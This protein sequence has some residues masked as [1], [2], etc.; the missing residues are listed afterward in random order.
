MNKVLDSPLTTRLLRTVGVEPVQYRLLL[1]LFSKLRDRQEFE[2]GAAHVSALK[3]VG[4]VAFFS[5]LV[6]FIVAFIVKAPLAVFAR[7]NY[8]LTAFLVL[9]ILLSEAINTFLNPVESAALAHQ[10]IREKSYFAA[11]LSYLLLITA[12]V[13]FP[14]NLVPSLLG[15]NLIGAR[16]F[17]PLL[18]LTSAY[19]LG[20]FIA[21]IGCGFLGILMR[22]IP[23][24]RVRSSVLWLQILFFGL[25]AVWPQLLQLLRPLRGPNSHLNPIYSSSIP[26]NWFVSLALL[27]SAETLDLHWLAIPSAFLCG[28]VV[29]FG[30]S[31]LTHGYLAQVHSLLRSGHGTQRRRSGW[32]GEAV[33]F[34]TGRQSGRAAFAFTYRMARTDWQFR[35]AVY[36][37]LIQLMIF[38][39]IAM[40]RAGIRISPFQPGPPS[41]AHFLPHI[42]GLAGFLVCSMITYSNQHGGAWIFL[43]APLDGIRSFAKGIFWALWL[44]MCA[45]PVLFM[46]ALAWY[47]GIFDAMLFAAYSIALVSFYLS[48]ELLLIDGLPFANPPRA[49]R[50]SMAAPLV[51]AA[52]IGAAIL[53]GLQWLFIFQSRFLTFGVA[54]VFAGTAYLLI[55]K[56]C[57]RY[58]EVNVAHNLHVIASGR[59]AMFKEIG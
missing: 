33:R 13:V 23:V 29:Y 39:A 27:G 14:L 40:V 35:R 28:L 36:P 16:W 15:L 11:K 7:G 21:L 2:L 24:V 6:N 18:H 45:V 9:L 31:S 4:L 8:F 3:I 54:L 1:N 47:W 42:S 32:F 17:Y 48:L 37:M 19:L 22:V 46:P 55:S 12:L 43:M 53:V 20:V 58:L 25:I 57:L 38:P 26:L 10:P 52:L 5:A 49:G 59:S 56:V 30:I 44:P 41:A 51:I 50:G 34:A